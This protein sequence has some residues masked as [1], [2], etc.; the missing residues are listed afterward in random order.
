MAANLRVRAVF[1]GGPGAGKGTQARRF[2]EQAKVVHISTGDML[3]QQVQEGGELGKQAKA[4]MDAGKLVPDELIIAMV[5]A[6]IQRP[7]AAAGWI[8]DGFP[9]TLAQAEALDRLLGP[10]SGP[11]GGTAL[12]QAVYFRVPDAVLKSR[13]TGRRICSQCGAIFHVDHKPTRKPGICDQCGGT[14]TQR[15]DDRAEAID[16]RLQEFH[17][18]TAEPLRAYYQ[19]RNIL[20]E[21]DADRPPDVIYKELVKLMQ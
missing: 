6:R 8:L 10:A 20:R 19:Q 7:D 16:K 14:T 9:R 5:Q 13:L 15:A 4:F 11:A 3:R 18:V 2:G 1:L 12:N 17:A 21:I